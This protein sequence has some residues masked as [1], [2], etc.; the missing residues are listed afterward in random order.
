M[1]MQ[2]AK[3]D[4]KDAK[5]SLPGDGF[6]PEHR[7]RNYEMCMVFRCKTSKFVKFDEGDAPISDFQ[8]PGSLIDPDPEA[9]KTMQMWKQRREAILKILENCGLRLFCY[10]SRDRDE[11][12][13]KIGAPPQKLRDTAARLKYKLKLK[14]Q[15]L[16]AYAEYRH[17]YPGRVV[18]HI[19]QTHTQD[20]YPD[21]DAIF[22]TLDKINLVHHMITSKDKDCA[23]IPV[24]DYMLRGDLKAYFPLHEVN[25]L[26]EMRANT[27][28]W[29]L[30]PEDFA[31]KFHD[32]FG[33]R[34]SFYFLFMSFYWRWLVP[35]AIFGV[36]LQVID[37][38]AH[39][40]DNITAIPFCILMSV[41]STFLPYFWRRQEAKYA[42]GWGSL[43]LVDTLERCRPEHYGDMRLNPVTSQVEPHFDFK[44][45][46]KFYA[47]SATTMT[48]TA[49]ITV[50]LVLLLC[51]L[52]HR[53]PGG[54]PGGLWGF[55]IFM[56]AFV[57]VAN[58]LLTKLA[59]KL[60]QLEN[61]RTQSEHETHQ[62]S[63]V[64]VL[65]FVCSYCVL[66]YA[67]FFK[68]H[69][70]LFGT[71]MQCWR[72][73]CLLDL[74]WQLGIFLVFRIIVQN[75]FEVLAPKV[76]MWW[77]SLYVDSRQGAANQSVTSMLHSMIHNH[78]SIELA[79]MSQAEQQSKKDHYDYFANF[80]DTL[81][82]HGF[83]T[84]FAVASPWVC[85][86]ALFSC[87]LEMAIK[88]RSLFDNHQRPLPYRARNNE[89]W[90][91]AFDIYGV[92]AAS[93]NITLLIFTSKE[94]QTWTFTEKL[95]LFIYLEHMIILARLALKVI[96]PEIPRNVELLQLKQDTMVHRCLENI[97]VEPNEDF[98]MFRD[99]R[100]SNIQVFDQDFLDREDGSEEKEPEFDFEGS[101]KTLL[102]GM[103]EESARLLSLKVEPRR[104]PPSQRRIA[105]RLSGMAP[106]ARGRTC[107]CATARCCAC[108]APR[109][110]WSAR[111]ARAV[112]RV[113]TLE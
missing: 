57:E 21:S 34:I 77:R 103:K 36:F 102:K 69:Q 83:T 71:K 110:L 58:Y 73:D 37:L 7:R 29:F 17:D 65:K 55:Q 104:L 109:A 33:D 42:V 89:P 48:F 84:F 64:M 76:K 19:Y 81:L 80:D 87:L 11:I 63:K 53:L 32:Y 8:Q 66:Y 113:C 101:M 105:P 70:Y 2:Y 108:L 16:N 72:D 93:T 68:Q 15:Y 14:Y 106:R 51:L 75:F 107:A 74:Q 39:S 61:H 3:L 96:F 92:L 4:G 43:D 49:A 35:L 44:Q 88:M 40:P 38:L 62:L 59:Q 26:A 47:L 100:A 54:V 56:A 1:T 82:T 23:G 31:N 86:A 12:I 111:G 97:K 79:N 9:L 22:R 10:H 27:R 25:P 45:R 85:L 30:M 18:S 5:A 94:Y 13:V 91:T 98:S 6:Y 20:D 112:A 60:T 28:A 67:A 95:V 52:R 99:Q 90:S 41:W 50:A 46:L 24:G 78:T